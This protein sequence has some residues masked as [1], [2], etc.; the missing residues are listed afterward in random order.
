MKL[1]GDFSENNLFSYLDECGLK[2]EAEECF[3]IE[4]A[5]NG[6]P[7][8]LYVKNAYLYTLQAALQNIDENP[9][10]LALT[11]VAQDISLSA[12]Y[13]LVEHGQQNIKAHK[14]E[15]NLTDNAIAAAII[16]PHYIIA[17]DKMEMMKIVGYEATRML[18]EHESMVASKGQHFHKSYMAETKTLHLACMMKDMKNMTIGLNAHREGADIFDK[19]TDPKIPVFLLYKHALALELSGKTDLETE[20]LDTQKTMIKTAQL[21][22]LSPTQTEPP[23]LRSVPTPDN[24]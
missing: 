15:L 7:D 21:A 13:T 3:A 6:L 18:A 5:Q 22:L 11:T 1:V 17:E 23:I 14:P 24:E 8:T 12:A 2:K 4:V 10:M 9:S 20:F 16:E 19:D